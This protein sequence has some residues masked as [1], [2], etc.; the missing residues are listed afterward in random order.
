MLKEIETKDEIKNGKVIVDFYSNTCAVCKR[1][2]RLFE[3]A[4][5]NDDTVNIIKINTASELGMELATEMNVSE[6]PSIRVLNNGV[7]KA[8]FTGI[9]NMNN[10]LEA[11]K[12]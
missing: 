10:I 5:N 8:K 1:M 6:L 2:L 3:Q 7:E 4:T 9:V 11:Y 12:Q